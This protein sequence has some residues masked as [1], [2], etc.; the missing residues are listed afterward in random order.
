MRGDVF[1]WSSWRPC[2]VS[3]AV[4]AVIHPFRAGDIYV[5]GTWC[6][7]L[8][9]M[10]QPNPSRCPNL[11]QT[12]STPKHSSSLTSPRVLHLL[13]K[14]NVRITSTIGIFSKPFIW[15]Q[16]CFEAGQ[17]GQGFPVGRQKASGGCGVTPFGC[18]SVSNYRHPQPCLRRSPNETK[19]RVAI[20]P[21]LPSIVP[22]ACT[23]AT[24]YLGDFRDSP[25]A[26]PC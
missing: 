26:K 11:Q 22:T 16:T 7:Y 6:M 9:I 19:C 21:C 4:T 24:R 15:S 2:N 25:L 10:T 23:T 3:I 14:T 1:F 18:R 17:R 13:R 20:Q 12:S 5:P 8:E